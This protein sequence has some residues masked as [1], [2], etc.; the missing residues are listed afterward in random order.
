M[1]DK[2]ND[3]PLYYGDV[4][5]WKNRT[6]VSRCLPSYPTGYSLVLLAEYFPVMHRES[7]DFMCAE[8]KQGNVA[9]LVKRISS[10][11]KS[12]CANAGDPGC[13]RMV[14]QV[15]IP[16]LSEQNGYVLS[17]QSSMSIPVDL[18]FQLLRNLVEF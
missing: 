11:L 9:S 17:S 10:E 15:R 2:C 18:L 8:P 14:S 5:V 7:A 4:D 1:A 13:R 12:K 6:A 3:K 16:I